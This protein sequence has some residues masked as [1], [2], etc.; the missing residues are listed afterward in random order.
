VNGRLTGEPGG[1]LVQGLEAPGGH[2]V[3]VDVEGRLI[4]LND[5]HSGRREIARLLV[6]GARERHGQG[7]PIP[8]M[9]VSQRVHDRH[10]AG[11]RELQAPIRVSAGPPHLVQMHGT[12][13]T[14][15]TRHR[16]HFGPVT[17]GADP[18]RDAPVEI[19]PFDVFQ[20]PVNEVLPRLFPVRD[21]IDAGRLL[22][23]EGNQHSIALGGGQLRAG[24]PPRRPQALWLGQPRRLGQ[25]SSN[26]GQEHP[27]DSSRRRYHD[28]VSSPT[29]WPEAR[30]TRGLVVSPH[31][32]A[33][34]AGLDILR[35][36]GNALDATVAA[37]TTIAVVYPHM[38]GIGGDSFWLMYDARQHTL[39]GLNA[40]GRSAAAVDLD[41]YR[42]NHGTTIP[43]R[44]GPAALT[45]PGVVSGW[46]EAHRYSAE[47]MGSSIG[48]GELLQSAIYHAREGFAPS[49]GQR[50]VTAA[51]SALFGESAPVE[52]RRTLWPLFHP[53]RLREARFVQL[54]LARTLTCVAE[55][56]AD[57]FYRGDLGR[58]LVGAAHEMGSPLSLEDLAAH[59]A[60]WVEPLRVAYHGG[61]AVSLPP[62][63]QGF[64]ALAILALL[65]S[66]DLA[67]LP[68]DN[69][70][71]L[72]VEATKLAFED[73]DRYL[74]DP[75]VEPVPVARCLDGE[76]LAR[77]RRRIS[78]GAAPVG[79]GP[80]ADGDTV[81]IVAADSR[82]NAVCLIQS[83]YHEF[84]AGI[85]GGD[86]GVLLQNR[87]AFF[88]LDPAH[89]NRLAPRKHTAHTLIPSMYLVN[90]RPRLV[91]GTMGGEGQPQTQAALL[92]RILHRGLGPQAA[93]EA[94]RWLL[95][96]TWG[97][98]TRALRLEARFESAVVASLAARGHEVRLVEAW[99]DLMGHAHVIRLDGD[100]LTG[101]S[102]PRAD[103]AALGV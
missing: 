29:R 72:I 57:E 61:E 100:G 10:G 49:A 11:K 23:L 94:P 32:L 4:E 43:P 39:L 79:G 3:H 55:G 78:Q 70:V 50:R 60:D 86:T 54:D 92:T 62:P 73:R 99:S 85:V 34:E 56:G 28:R 8:I 96:R 16:G 90:G 30:A 65:E 98:E 59:R 82:G 31:R 53:D 102:D 80:P 18:D 71:H 24:H 21:D 12:A 2:V 101:G 9:L 36:G 27:P 25:A 26:G 14:D 17:V 46:W 58:R 88:S 45:V 51:A 91:Y 81:A 33:S 95:G 75:S 97:E 67:T 22:L 93:V 5:V 63:T 35:Q 87:G 84:G 52:V 69:Y 77:R 7:R 68:E 83:L 103:G 13:P 6:E 66:F 15:R 41:A 40:A 20:E 37:A 89:P 47:R 64:A 19:D 38:N 48:W 76:R 42:A 74:T 44:G 1:G